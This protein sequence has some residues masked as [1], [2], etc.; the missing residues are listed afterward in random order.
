MPP[1]DFANGNSGFTGI[2]EAAPQLGQSPVM[3][4]VDG[5]PGPGASSP[6]EILQALLGKTGLGDVSGMQTP[7]DPAMARTVVERGPGG[8]G[9]GDLLRNRTVQG[10]QPS[11]LFSQLKTWGGGQGVDF[12]ARPLIGGGA[13]FGGGG[14]APGGS[15][16]MM[17]PS[18]ASPSEVSDLMDPMKRVNAARGTDIGSPAAMRGPT[19]MGTPPATRVD[20]TIPGN[21]GG[22]QLGAPMVPPRV[23]PKGVMAGGVG[24]G[25]SVD[26]MGGATAVDAMGGATIVQGERSAVSDILSGLLGRASSLAPAFFGGLDAALADHDIQPDSG[27]MFEQGMQEGTGGEN[28]SFMPNNMQSDPDAPGSASDRRPITAIPLPDSPTPP[29]PTPAKRPL[30]GVGKPVQPES[31]ARGSMPSVPNM[32]LQ[33]GGL[34]RGGPSPMGMGMPGLSLGNPMRTPL[35]PQPEV[36]TSDEINKRL[37]ARQ[38]MMPGPKLSA[39]EQNFDPQRFMGPPNNRGY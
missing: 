21:L 19:S 12:G 13:G 7:M 32:Q 2:G 37:M 38:M 28:Q 23:P 17:G 29:S 10:Q 33:A 35:Q 1:H 18:M 39:P 26:A 20:P 24:G 8:G 27:P 15:A 16:S 25:T 3:R 4:G 5:T 36:A 11:D 9:M 22:R 30:A 14:A 6:E 31:P 34:N